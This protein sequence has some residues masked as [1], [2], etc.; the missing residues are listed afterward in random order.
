MLGAIGNDSQA[1]ATLVAA[2]IAAAAAVF[3]IMR[4]YLRNE[5][6][7]KALRSMW[8]G[9]L[10]ELWQWMELSERTAGVADWSVPKA[11]LD[12]AFPMLYTAASF[13]GLRPDQAIS[14][15]AAIHSVRFAI[16]RIEDE[17]RLAANRRRT[18]LSQLGKAEIYEHERMA[19]QAISKNPSELL[20]TA[21]RSLDKHN[22][23]HH[24]RPL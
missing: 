11:G 14:I 2:L 5:D 16:H 9:H 8:L 19:T 12:T 15:V 21:I 7:K 4:E 17:Q 22:A 23:D 24:L 3:G 6:R 10:V 18:E 1:F 20:V 13:G